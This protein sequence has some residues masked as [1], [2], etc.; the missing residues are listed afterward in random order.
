MT[1][2]HF[3]EIAFSLNNQGRFINP[4]NFGD[5]ELVHVKMKFEAVELEFE[6]TILRNNE[7]SECSSQIIKIVCQSPAFVGFIS[8]HLQNVVSE[9]LLFDRDTVP[10]VDLPINEFVKLRDVLARNS[11]HR[12]ILVIK[13]IVGIDLVVLCKSV[14][15]FASDESEAISVH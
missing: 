2:Q 7:S 3:L 5:S 12:F 6:A 10:T 1:S 4:E 9:V 13:P 8:D 14:T 11:S 15:V